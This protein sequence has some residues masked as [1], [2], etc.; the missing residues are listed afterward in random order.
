M[1]Q[2]TIKFRM[3]DRVDKVMHDNPDTT[4]KTDSVNGQFSCDEDEIWMQFTGLADKNGREIYEGEIIKEI[5]PN[6]P[7]HTRRKKRDNYI[8]SFRNGCFTAQGYNGDMPIEPNLDDILHRG[9]EVI[10]NIYENP[11]LLKQ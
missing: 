10:G 1:K 8:I 3:W 2:R 6:L 9:L 7:S 11:E 4:I 5:N